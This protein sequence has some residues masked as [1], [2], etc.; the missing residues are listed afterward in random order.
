M[1]IHTNAKGKF[2]CGKYQCCFALWKNLCIGGKKQF[3]EQEIVYPS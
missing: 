2:K 1:G 3:M